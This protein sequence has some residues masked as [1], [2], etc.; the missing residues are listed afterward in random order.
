MKDVN[1]IAQINICIASLVLRNKKEKGMEED[2]KKIDDM[3]EREDFT[4]LDEIYKKYFIA[5]NAKPE[6]E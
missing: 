4:G 3:F 1:K 5:S 2:L 6:E